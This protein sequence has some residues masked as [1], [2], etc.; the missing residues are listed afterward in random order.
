MRCSHYMIIQIKPS[1]HWTINCKLLQNHWSIA[2]RLLFFLTTVKR[3]SLR[4]GTENPD[5]QQTWWR[6]LQKRIIHTKFDIYIYFFSVIFCSMIIQVSMCLYHRNTWSKTSTLQP[7]YFKEF[8]FNIKRVS[9]KP[10]GQT[11]PCGHL[12]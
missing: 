11:Y 8:Y 4:T 7:F 10:N 12:Y 6:L 5:K 1:N 2:N 3:E 9:M